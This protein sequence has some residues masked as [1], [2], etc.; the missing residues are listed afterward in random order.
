MSQPFPFQASHCLGVI[1]PHKFRGGSAVTQNHFVR[2]S[3]LVFIR[4]NVPAEHWLNA[5][6][7]EE[8]P[9]PREFFVR[10]LP[11]RNRTALVFI[12]FDSPAISTKEKS[13]D[14]KVRASPCY[15]HAK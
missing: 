7:R 10:N 12:S 13:P 15:Q 8:I 3:E 1:E 14:A 4:K 6:G 2:T 9:P 5:Q 11:L